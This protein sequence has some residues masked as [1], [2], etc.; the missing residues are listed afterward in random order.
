VP[1]F[2]FDL[3][4]NGRTIPDED[5][6]ELLSLGAARLEAARTAGEMLRDRTQA[7]AEP[8]DICLIVRDGSPEPACSIVVA[9][10]IL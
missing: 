2:Y 1:R 9:L 10:K 8:A 5:G 6:V 3:V 7:K 4:E